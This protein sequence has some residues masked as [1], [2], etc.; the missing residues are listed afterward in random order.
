LRRSCNG[1]K[2]QLAAKA[3]IQNGHSG[4]SCSTDGK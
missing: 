3:K 4:G 1:Y 2:K